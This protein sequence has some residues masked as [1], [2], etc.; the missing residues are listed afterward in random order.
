MKAK[1]QVT[2]LLGDPSLPDAVKKNGQFNDEDFET[3]EKLKEALNQIKGFS[4]TYLDHHDKL[5]HEL[6]MNPPKLV[7]NLCDEGFNNDP[8]KELHVTALLEM[9]NI[10]YTGAGPSCLA[11]CYNKANVRAIAQNMGVPVPI[12]IYIAHDDDTISIPPFFPAL[13]KPNMGDSSLVENTQDLGNYIGYLKEILPGKPILIQEFLSGPEYSVGLIGNPNQFEV[14][15]IL[16]VD[17]SRLDPNLPKILAY[18]SKWE[19]ESPYWDEI[20]YKPAKLDSGTRR[21]L[22]EY[23]Q[24]LFERCG[25]SDY[26]RMDFRCDVNGEIKLLEVNPNP[27]WCWDGKLNLMAEHVELSYSQLLEAILRAAVERYGL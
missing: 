12:E 9:L 20:K 4:F 23:S 8:L 14:L 7:L 26:A 15:P 1:Q 19:P 25:C 3:V 6:E 18:E 16:E 5:I 24:Q 2:V 27:G 17:Y 11:L 22:T 21:R 13:I 10:P